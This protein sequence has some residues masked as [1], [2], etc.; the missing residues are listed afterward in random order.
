MIDL[1]SVLAFFHKAKW[2]ELAI[3]HDIN[4]ALGENTIN[5]STVRKCVRMIVLSTKETAVPEWESDFSPEDRTSIV[6]SEEP[7][8]SARQFVNEVM[9]SKSTVYR[10]STQTMRRKLRHLASALTV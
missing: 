3:T 1:N 5:S 7:F 10:N 4:R 9:I 2:T 6:L 8:L